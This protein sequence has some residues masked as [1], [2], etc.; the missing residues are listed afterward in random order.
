VRV[1]FIGGSLLALSELL[2]KVSLPSTI[3][4]IKEAGFYRKI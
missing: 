2:S 3:D 1:F 4:F